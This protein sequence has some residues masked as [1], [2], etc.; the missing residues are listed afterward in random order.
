MTVWNA[1]NF[2]KSLKNIFLN[3]FNIPEFWCFMLGYF[4]KHKHLIS[5]EYLPSF[6]GPWVSSVEVRLS[7][8][9]SICLIGHPT[10]IW[11]IIRAKHFWCTDLAGTFL[12]FGWNSVCKSEIKLNNISWDTNRITEI[13]ALYWFSLFALGLT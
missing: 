7:I 6:L 3:R 10:I 4:F 5:K 8:Y 12:G 13:S 2:A 11:E 9:L 1:S